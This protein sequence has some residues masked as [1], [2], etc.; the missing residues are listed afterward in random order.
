M[1]VFFLTVVNVGF[2]Q[3]SLNL[4]RTMMQLNTALVQKDSSTLNKLLADQLSYAHSNGW[5]ET[6][7]QIL[8]DLYNGVLSYNNITIITDSIAVD[9]DK[10]I[11]KLTGDFYV[12]MKGEDMK[13]RL[14]V[15]QM[16]VWENKQWKLLKR[17]SVKVE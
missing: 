4:R 12:Q 9:G 10:G 16:W 8:E 5:I 17:K 1:F 3:D 13:F 6:K 2:A 7:H 14:N 11:V 15:A